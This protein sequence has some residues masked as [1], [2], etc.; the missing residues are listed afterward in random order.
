[1][2]ALVIIDM[3]T[4]FNTP[5]KALPEVLKRIAEFKN[6]NR[7]IVLVE[8]RHF[9]HTIDEVM[10]AIGDYPTI[11]VEKSNDDGGD[12]VSKVLKKYHRRLKALTLCGVNTCYCVGETALNLTS[13]G[14]KVK[15][16]GTA[17]HNWCDKAN[18]VENLRK[19]IKKREETYGHNRV[20]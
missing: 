14:Y 17:C 9:G 5:K 12:E 15:I 19:N 2:P 3:Q 18:C 4:G 16:R 13:N 1:M 7:P 6:A 8:Y 10:Q 20:C 11:K